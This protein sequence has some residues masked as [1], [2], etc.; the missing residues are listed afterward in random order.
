MKTPM[1]Q[2]VKALLDGD[3]V[4]AIA[5]ARRLRGTGVEDERIVTE[6]ME[7]AMQQLDG[8]CT[9]EQFNLLEIMLTG[10]AV[11]G[12]MKE[13]YPAGAT[14][15][16]TKGTVVMASPEGDVHDLGKNILKVLLMA[17]AYHV[18]DCGKDCPT[19]RLIEIAEREGARAV[20]VSGLISSLIPQVRQIRDEMRSQGLGH[21]KVMA[22]G[23]ALKQASAESLNVDFVAQTAFDGARYLDRV[24]EGEQ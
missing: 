16:R 18:V 24:V 22:G 8:K 17:K 1:D 3:Q 12:V 9:M 19:D 13:L 14:S 20:A 5:E 2:L 21:I 15:L 4:Q 23:A 11:M 10:R 7:A 6:G